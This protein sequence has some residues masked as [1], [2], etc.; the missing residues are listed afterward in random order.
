MDFTSS[1]AEEEREN[2]VFSLGFMYGT[3]TIGGRLMRGEWW[4]VV[5]VTPPV[6]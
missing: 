6:N 5:G 3:Y 4:S 1:T 2:V